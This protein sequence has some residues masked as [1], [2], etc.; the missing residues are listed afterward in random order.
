[1]API[2]LG[3]KSTYGELGRSP[4]N[5]PCLHF[6]HRTNP[7]DRTLTH[8]VRRWRHDERPSSSNNDI[9]IEGEWTHTFSAISNIVKE[10]KNH[11]CPKSRATIDCADWSWRSQKPCVV[12]A[13]SKFALFCTWVKLGP[14][15]CAVAVPFWVGFK[16]F[17]VL[18]NFHVIKSFTFR[19]K[20]LIG[21]TSFIGIPHDL[22]NISSYI[23]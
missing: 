1:M 11:T 20:P 23:N 12:L 22:C 17:L 9:Q 4:S 8:T 21:D 5:H 10:K 19:F 18:Y 13:Q 2:D 3:S 14:S 7:A 16:V 15:V 6:Q